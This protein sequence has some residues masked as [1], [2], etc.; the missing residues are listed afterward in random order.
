MNCLTSFVAP[1]DDWIAS[2]KNHLSIVIARF[3]SSFIL[4][5]EN[6]LCAQHMKKKV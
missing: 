1:I 6:L 5:K 3:D 4:N 2:K